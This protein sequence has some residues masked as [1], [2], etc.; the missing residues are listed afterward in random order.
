MKSELIP[1][2]YDMGV[3]STC[4]NGLVNLTKLF[5]NSCMVIHGI[6]QMEPLY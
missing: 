2:C 1:E 4:H 3:K 6:F 5:A